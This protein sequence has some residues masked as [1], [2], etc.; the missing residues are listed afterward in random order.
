MG[1][2][3]ISNNTNEGSLIWYES[4]NKTQ[5]LKWVTL[6]DEFLESKLYFCIIIIFFFFKASATSVKSFA[7]FIFPQTWG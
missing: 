2:R 3:P 4:A 5:I 1:Y 6:I 7:T